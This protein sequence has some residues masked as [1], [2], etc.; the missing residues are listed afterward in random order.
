LGPS[1]TAEA[2]RD[3][4]AIYSDSKNMDAYLKLADIAARQGQDQNVRSTLR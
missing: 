2:N 1:R 3:L 4:R